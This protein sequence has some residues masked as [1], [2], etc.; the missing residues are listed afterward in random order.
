MDGQIYDKEGKCPKCGMNLSKQK[1]TE[2]QIKMMK[3][4]TSFKPKE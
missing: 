4:G 1:M 3:K 2:E